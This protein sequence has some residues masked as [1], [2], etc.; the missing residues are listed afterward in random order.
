M[1]VERDLEM[2]ASDGTALRSD[3]YA[4]A[5]ERSHP[6]ILIRTPYDKRRLESDPYYDIHRVVDAGYI[7]VCQDVRGLF[8]SDGQWESNIRFQTHDAQDGYDT[9]EWAGR[10]PRANG[11]V[12]T[13]GGSYDAFLQWRLAPLHPPSLIAMS[14]QTIPAR[15]TDLEGPGTIRPGKRLHWW[16]TKMSSELRRRGGRPGPHTREEGEERWRSGQGESLLRFLPWLDLPQEVFED[17]TEPMKDWLRQPHLDPWNLD[18]GCPDVEVPNL[19][20]VGWYDH[21]NGNMRMFTS[22]VANAKTE[23]ARSQS[24]IIIG[25][26]SHGEWGRTRYGAIDF[27]SVASLDG[28]GEVL[29]WFDYWLKGR[30]PGFVA[31]PPVRIFVM[32]DGRWRGE[33]TWPPTDAQELSLFLTS[34]GSANTPAGDG[35][36]AFQLP[37]LDGVDEYVYDP[38]DPVPDLLAPE[39][40]SQ[41][42]DQRLLSRRRDILVYT[43]PPLSER[44]EVTGIPVAEIVA[45]SS[46]PD[47]DF[48]V[49][50]I[51]VEPEGIARDVSLGV[52]RARFRDGVESQRLLLPNEIVRYR[53]PMSPTS[54]AFLPGH[55]IRIDITSSS[56]PSFDRNH[57]SAALP[58]A[59]PEL[60]QARQRVHHGRAH[61]SRVVLPWLRNDQR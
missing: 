11:R 42:T 4:P 60:K 38:T 23:L 21:C 25:P 40:V 31:E 57:N 16:A 47:T 30:G 20:I 9:V 46:A 26:W 55:R 2:T 24:R 53:I 37:D 41:P 51:D 17:E 35:A 22:T 49:R 10:L 36:L 48:F 32:G 3:V 15:Y 7:V 19:D 54:N 8:A 6:V 13:L 28:I 56:F 33:A 27:G 39:I 12:G 43:S 14:A 34:L 18:S 61:R 59:D 44:I 1:N 45:Q 52:V 5:G 29:R 50:L 58:N